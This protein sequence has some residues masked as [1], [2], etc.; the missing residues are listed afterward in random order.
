M[1]FNNEVMVDEL[2]NDLFLKNGFLSHFY[3]YLFV[4]PLAQCSGHK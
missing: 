3:T 1:Q 2:E 4:T